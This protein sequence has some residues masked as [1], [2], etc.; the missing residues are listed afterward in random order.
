MALMRCCGSVPYRTP[1]SPSWGR[2][3]KPG[4]YIY[5]YIYICGYLLCGWLGPPGSIARVRSWEKVA[6][7]WELCPCGNCDISVFFFVLKRVEKSTC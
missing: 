4:I 5:I 7:N 2:G 6:E 3:C 1:K